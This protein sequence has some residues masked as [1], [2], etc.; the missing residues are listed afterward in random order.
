MAHL[1]ATSNVL[2]ANMYDKISGIRFA[3]AGALAEATGDGRELMVMGECERGR[4]SIEC[5][6]A[7]NGPPVGYTGRLKM[8]I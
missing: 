1:L 3:T 2:D 7:M 5:V 6:Y 8:W 4:G